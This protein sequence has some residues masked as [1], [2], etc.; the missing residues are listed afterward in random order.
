LFTETVLVKASWKRWYGLAEIF[1]HLQK[2]TEVKQVKQACAG[3]NVIYTV[4]QK[5][6]H[7]RFLMKTDGGV[8]NPAPGVVVD[9]DL[10]SLD[11]SDF[12]L[13]PTECNLSTVKPV[14]Y[15]ILENPKTLPMKELQQL[16]Y[17]LCHCYPNWTGNF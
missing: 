3:A 7:T 8:A 11:Y 15:V 12:Y 10:T 2:Q 17:N 9:S 5:R 14:R 6:I 16:T 1:P 13:I 4:V